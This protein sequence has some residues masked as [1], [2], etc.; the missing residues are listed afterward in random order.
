MVAIPNRKQSLSDSGVDTPPS[1]PLGL[2]GGIA[3]PNIFRVSRPA[4]TNDPD[5]RSTFE[6]TDDLQHQI[7]EG[8]FLEIRV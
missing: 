5:S 4:L 1:L 3:P 6:S 8:A 7:V 2:G